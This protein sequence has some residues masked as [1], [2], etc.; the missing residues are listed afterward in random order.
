MCIGRA[1]LLVTLAR[2]IDFLV[3]CIDLALVAELGAELHPHAQALVQVM[4]HIGVVLSHEALARRRAL[5]LLKGIYRP[6]AAA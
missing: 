4:Q 6:Y 1:L 5:H 3:A 2:R